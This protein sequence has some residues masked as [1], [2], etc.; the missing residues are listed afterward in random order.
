MKRNFLHAATVAAAMLLL[1]NGC[2]D[3]MVAPQAAATPKRTPALAQAPY[4]P[5]SASSRTLYQAQLGPV[6]GTRD[7]G[8]VKIEIAGGYLVVSVHGEGL[9]PLRHIPQHI[10]A[11]ATCE[12]PGLPV[13]NLDANL[14]LPS[15]SPTTG[16]NF[17]VAN[18]GG[19]VSYQASRS[20]SSLLPAINSAHQLALGSVDELVEW[21]DLGNR[22]VH[23]HASDAPFTP[24]TCGTVN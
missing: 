18:A 2:D 23:M 22:N 15:E 4:T 13:I 11:N 19:S 17:P 1:A 24:M 8:T 5:G 3:G 16:D 14:S 6:N 20:L 12:N 9:D 21:L 7:H 10:H